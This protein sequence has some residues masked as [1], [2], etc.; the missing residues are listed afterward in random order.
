MG[1]GEAGNVAE[2]HGMSKVLISARNL[3]DYPQTARL[4]EIIALCKQISA[5]LDTLQSTM[6]DNLRYLESLVSQQI[7]NEKKTKYDEMYK[8]ATDFY[9]KYYDIYNDYSNLVEAMETYASNPT[10]ANKAGVEKQYGYLWNSNCRLH[11]SRR[12]E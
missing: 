2:G 3:L 10:Q 5:Q 7:A 9:T 6:S 4:E 11:G 12:W 1:L 8:K